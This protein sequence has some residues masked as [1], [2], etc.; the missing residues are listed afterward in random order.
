MNL[1]QYFRKAFRKAS[2]MLPYVGLWA[3]LAP[4]ITNPRWFSWQATLWLTGAWF[5]GLAL[6]FGLAIKIHRQKLTRP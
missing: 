2:P 5:L 4:V 1:K 6:L 3:C